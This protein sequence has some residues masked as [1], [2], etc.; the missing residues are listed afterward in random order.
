MY[1]LDRERRNGLGADEDERPRREAGKVLVQTWEGVA[2][3]P[4]VAQSSPSP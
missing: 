4:A 1:I 3:S 2:A